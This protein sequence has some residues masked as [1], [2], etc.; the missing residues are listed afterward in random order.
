MIQFTKF[1]AWGIGWFKQFTCLARLAFFFMFRHTQTQPCHKQLFSIFEISR[2]FWAYHRIPS[3]SFCTVWDRSQVRHSTNTLISF[4]F[5]P[6]PCHRRFF[7][8]ILPRFTQVQFCLFSDSRIT[9]KFCCLANVF[10]ASR[11]LSWTAYFLPFRA[12]RPASLFAD[13]VQV[14]CPEAK[15]ELAGHLIPGKLM[16]RGSHLRD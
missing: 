6:H 3:G 12:T 13:L 16:A 7:Q 15:S 4:V 5:H 10:L 14:D 11:P 9:Q 8:R 2:R 1:C